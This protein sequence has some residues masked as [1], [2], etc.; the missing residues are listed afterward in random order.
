M[1]AGPASEPTATG[2]PRTFTF[3]GYAANSYKVFLCIGIYAGALAAAALAS[4]SGLSPLSVGLTGMACALAGLVGARVYFLLVNLPHVLKQRSLAEAW[5]GREGG[6]SVFGGLLP[7]IAIAFAASSL[8]GIPLPILLDHIA[9]GI[10]VGGF[11][12]RLGCVFNGCCAGRETHGP[13]RVHLHDTRGVIKPRIPVQFLEM[14]WWLL[15]MLGFLMLWPRLLPHG[16]Y[17]LAV[18]TWYGTGRF[19]LEPLRERP[20]IVF[21]RVRINQLVAVVLA[22]ASGAALIVR[23]WG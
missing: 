22:I 5:N 8:T 3:A 11:W 15:G 2:F 9:F 23:G 16:S 10:L 13:L 6:W 7:L 14:G 1:S 21:G 18:L 19:V 12:I 17:I 4:A 20:D